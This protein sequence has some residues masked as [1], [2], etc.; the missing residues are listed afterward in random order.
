MPA[1][2]SIHRLKRF[3]LAGI[4]SWAAFA[5]GYGQSPP[6]PRLEC[7]PITRPAEDP[8]PCPAWRW[9]G[10]LDPA[11]VKKGK[12]CPQ[13]PGWEVRPLFAKPDPRAK[14][15]P[16]GLRPF[17]LYEHPGAGEDLTLKRPR[18]LASIERDCMAVLPQGSALTDV[19]LPQLEAYF[20]GQAG[21][22]ELSVSPPPGGAPSVRL[23]LL[24]TAPTAQDPAGDPRNHSPHG[25]TL[26]NMAKKLTCTVSGACAAKVTAQL[27]LPWV[28]YEPTSRALSFRDEVHGG[29]IGMIGELAQAIRDEVVAW[30][31]DD[32]FK[33]L[34]LNLS[35]AWNPVFGGGEN[36]PD[37][38]DMGPAVQA[39]HAALVDALCRGVPAVAAAGNRTWDPDDGSDAGPLLP[40]GWERLPAPTAQE[41][42][43]ALRPSAPVALG[44][45]A[46]RSLVSAVGGVD[47]S[48]R[49]LRNARPGAEPRLVAFGDHAVVSGKEGKPTA[50]LTGSSV[51]TLVAA[52]A[53]S[54]VR[55]DL[56]QSAVFDAI[57]RL[58]R[59]GADS[60]RVAV[61]SLETTASASGNAAVAPSVRRLFTAKSAANP[62]WIA[63]PV[64]PLTLGVAAY[65][66]FA[67]APRRKLAELTAIAPVAPR[68]NTNFGAMTGPQ[69]G[70]DPCSGCGFGPPA[71][72][73]G[74]LYLEID[75]DYIGELSSPALQVGQA[76]YDLH[77]VWPNLMPGSK[78]V[79]TGITVNPG[80]EIK[81][82]FLVNSIRSATSLPL[83]TD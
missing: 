52:S 1:G 66:N 77:G 16:E 72:S 46:Y 31:T 29:L 28:V 22:F 59:S 39:V 81:I 5:G 30:Q 40:A 33:S 13:L 14:D 71:T 26:A 44:S 37:V 53:L 19:A 18:E 20:L 4:G 32:P 51:S 80:E 73:S 3:S 49:S 17:C 21:G 10:V 74:T 8:C 11:A 7:P 75:P 36:Q 61:L 2:G 54:W 23:G 9:I 65:R 56:P 12:G 55:S 41:C 69:P 64:P 60:G 57:D 25:Y 47:A 50:M 79:L 35:V 45:S 67:T 42:T 6:A 24:D 58:Y 82:S 70:S 43:D 83:W 76:T 34:V 63:P 27:A 48:G 68:R 15:V 62:D 38:D 78:L